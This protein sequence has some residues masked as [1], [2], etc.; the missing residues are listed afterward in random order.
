MGKRISKQKKKQVNK[1]SIFKKAPWLV[2]FPLLLSAVGLFF[3]YEAS[4]IYSLEIYGDSF[5]F[6]KLQTVWLAAAFVAMVFFALFPYRYLYSFSVVL[7][8]ATIGLLISVLVIGKTINGAQSWIDLG[9]FNL[10]PT[11]FAKFSII[12]YL[13]SWFVQMENKRFMSFFLLVSL[14]LFLIILQPDI[15]SAIVIFMLSVSIYF[16]A[17]RDWYKLLIFVPLGGVAF[18]MLIK[19]AP[20]RFNR[21][22]AFLHPENDPLGVSYHINQILI[23][24][25][26]GGL[27]GKGFGASRQKYL[28]LPEAHTD[29]IFAIIGEEFG[30]IGCSLIIFAFIALLYMLYK[31][32]A[33]TNEPFGKLLAGGIFIYFALQ[34]LVNL[35]GMVALMPLTG[36]PLPFISYGGSHLIPSFALMGIAISIVR[37]NTSSK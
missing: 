28:F 37:N 4:S 25:A 27:F 16:L 7:M 3:V 8:L 22:M 20:Y 34:S 15:G 33:S 13:S 29:S 2:F 24:L 6:L 9:P 36:V 31:V 32:Y 26:S 23:S 12:I 17:G 14:L 21:L 5:R 11:E 18:F 35:G 19:A 10:Q 1:Q 30:L